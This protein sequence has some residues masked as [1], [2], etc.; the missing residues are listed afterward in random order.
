MT[1]K[2]LFLAVAS[3]L[4]AVPQPASAQTVANPTATVTVAPGALTIVSNGA[5]VTFPALTLDGT[6]KP[7][8]AATVAPVFTLTDATGTGAGWNVTVASTD[9]VHNDTPSVPGASIAVSNFTY[10]PTSGTITRVSGQGVT[11]PGGPAETGVATTALG[12]PLKSVVAE[13]NFGRGRYTWSPAA[14]NFALTVPPET[15]AGGYTATMTFTIS[16]GP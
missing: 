15:I 5:S 3:L 6:D 16:S 9:F 13:P 1:R 10:A 14:G 7:P 4:L 11:T 2:F 12:T 8:L